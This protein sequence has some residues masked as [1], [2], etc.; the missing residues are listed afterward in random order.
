MA[1]GCYLRSLWLLCTG[2]MPPCNPSGIP[3]PGILLIKQ[4]GVCSFLIIA[5]V[6]LILS[7]L[8]VGVFVKRQTLI[9]KELLQYKTARKS[10]HYGEPL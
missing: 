2:Y 10:I 7:H 6:Q 3:D 1:K 9:A 4:I 5:F 8:V